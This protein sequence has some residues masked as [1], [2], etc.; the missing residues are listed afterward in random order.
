MP[1]AHNALPVCPAGG[2]TPPAFV[3]AV[4]GSKHAPFLAPNLT[5]LFNTYSALESPDTRGVL[6][7]WQDVARREIAA[8]RAAFPAARFIETSFPTGTDIMH[9]IPRKIHAWLRGAELAI[10]HHPSRPVVFIDCD[11]MLIR[12]IDDLL[13]GDWDVM[14]TWKDELYPINTGVM[15]AR[16]ASAAAHVFR[17]MLPRIERMV[18]HKDELA[19]AVGSSGA[20]DQHALREIIGFC[21][22]D[23]TFSRSVAV[24]PIQREIVFRGAP[25]RVLNETRC[26]PIGDFLRI[27]HYK[28][29]WHPILLDGKPFT[30]NRSKEA[31]GE[32]FALWNDLE[33]QAAEGVASAVVHCGA[34]AA[35]AR[36]ASIAGGYEERGILHSEMLAACGAFTSMGV[37]VVIESGRCR[38]QSTR[39]LADFFAGSPIEIVSLELVRDETSDF[40]EARLAGHPNVELLYGDT[41]AMLPALLERFKGRRIGLLL[42]GPKG[43]AAMNLAHQAF[44]SSDDVAV[45]CIHDMRIDFPQRAASADYPFRAFFTDDAEYRRLYAHLDDACLPTGDISMHTWRPFKKGHEDIDGYG[46]TLGVFLPRPSRTTQPTPASMG[47]KEFIHV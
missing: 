8:L 31:C 12:P 22:Y 32:M 28:T 9:A 47:I 41:T 46:P 24:G 35:A 43:V 29:G 34:A 17:T 25:C 15:A 40:A 3:V 10:E 1:N 23:G 19:T 42:D 18:A 38:G 27:V 6:V 14:F 21:N 20:A 37:D 44:S 4:Y 11:A 45:A 26:V 7:L 36:F 5:R 33:S 16:D 39:I 2:T 30:A 13:A